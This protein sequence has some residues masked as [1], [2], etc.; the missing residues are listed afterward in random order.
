MQAIL[1]TTVILVCGFVVLTFLLSRE[2]LIWIG[3]KR[4][5]ATAL[6]AD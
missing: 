5:V 6:I 4:F 2:P 3:R 1:M